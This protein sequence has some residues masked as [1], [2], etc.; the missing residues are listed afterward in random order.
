MSATRT[1]GFAI[2]FRRGWGKWQT[3]TPALVD[4]ARRQGFGFVDVGGNLDL[5]KEVAATGFALGSVDLASFNALITADQAERAKLIETNCEV[6][7]AAADAGAKAMFTVMLPADRD[8]DRKENYD[9]MIASY[10]PLVK[11]AEQLGLQIV[12]EGWPGPGALCCTPESLR[13]LLDHFS[14]PG[15]GVNYDPS[16]LVRLGVDHLRF[17]T[18]FVGHV[19]HV[20]AKDTE[21]FTE[22]TY[23]LGTELKPV[24]TDGIGFGANH[25]RYT[26]P[27]HGCV[28]WG[29]AFAIL[30]DAGYAGGVS[31]E[32][33]DANFN[34]SEDGEK[35][36][37]THSLE[38]LTGC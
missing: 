7:R 15:I 35:A 17:L 8:A 27:G 12:I 26:I 13:P 2:G 28:R 32:L 33:E 3:D 11:L 30:A 9:L 38:Y 18:E 16:H 19:Y 34:G 20:H 4:W 22:R 37:L 31:V 21:L 14:S 36:G 23:E 24:F 6:F 29:E 1:G 5:I 25:W 10:E